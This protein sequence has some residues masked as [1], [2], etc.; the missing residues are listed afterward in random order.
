MNLG[1]SIGAYQEA[2]G[3]EA[4]KVTGLMQQRIMVDSYRHLVSIRVVF[5]QV[6]G[7]FHSFSCNDFLVH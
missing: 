6:D 7:N 4:L 3:P 2:E 5:A 1:N